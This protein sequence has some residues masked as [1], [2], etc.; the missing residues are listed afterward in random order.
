[1]LASTYSNDPKVANAGCHV[2]C[3]HPGWVQT[4]MGS[5]NGT[6][7]ADC[8]TG[9]SPSTCL[10]NK[11]NV[12]LDALYSVLFYRCISL[13]FVVYG[14]WSS[15]EQSS[16]GIIDV[17]YLAAKVQWERAGDNGTETN[18]ETKTNTN[19]KLLGTELRSSNCVF[20]DYKGKLLPW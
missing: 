7:T 16:K 5:S 10:P 6:R 15:P 19:M 14:C 12:P 20:C 18:T 4:D 3:M 11:H 1:M 13:H 17:A 9:E 2:V 8:T